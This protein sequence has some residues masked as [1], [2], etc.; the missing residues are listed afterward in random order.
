MFAQTKADKLAF[1]FF[2]LLLWYFLSKPNKTPVEWVLT[3]FAAAGAAY[4]GYIAL[5]R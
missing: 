1:P 2:V 4:D 3:L 5:R